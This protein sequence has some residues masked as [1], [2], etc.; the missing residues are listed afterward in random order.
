MSKT[1]GGT[2]GRKTGGKEA[3]EYIRWI[4]MK[5]RCHNPNNNRYNLYGGR[6]IKVCERWK[7]S[8]ENF[9]KDM[10]LCPENHFLDRIDSNKEYSPSNCRWVTQKEQQNNRRNNFRIEFKG[11]IKTSAQWAEELNFN[12]TTIH[13]RLY[14]LGWTIEETLMTPLRKCRARIGTS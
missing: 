14:K 10:G 1:H 3:R 4:A 7:N 2:I 13:A 6:G 11:I 8:Y 9:L 12:T 5:S